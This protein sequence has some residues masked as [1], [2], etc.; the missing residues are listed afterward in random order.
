MVN[1]KWLTPEI[2]SITN[3]TQMICWRTNPRSKKPVVLMFTSTTMQPKMTP[4]WAKWKSRLKQTD[5]RRSMKSK[6]LSQLNTHLT[7]RWSSLEKWDN[8]N[9]LKRQR[10]SWNNRSNNSNKQ[11]STMLIVNSR[12]SRTS[13]WSNRKWKKERLES[14][15]FETRE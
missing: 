5:K 2:K 11:S 14:R 4:T 1:T 12:K 10:D 7:R 9:S 13:D 8:S 6:L 15:K 3:L